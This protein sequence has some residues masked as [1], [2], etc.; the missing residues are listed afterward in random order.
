MN[1]SLSPTDGAD[2]LWSIAWR[3][4]RRELRGGLSGFRI[5][6]ACLALGVGSIAAVGNVSESV[7][8]AL[9]RD[10]RKLLGGDVELRL[11]HQEAT[12]DQIEW[13]RA[14]TERVAELATMRTTAYGPDQRRLVELKGGCDRGRLA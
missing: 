11:T 9:E 14:N 5:F 6:L 3:V 13:L 2:R 8:S 10:G 12:G 1:T 7:L 4:C